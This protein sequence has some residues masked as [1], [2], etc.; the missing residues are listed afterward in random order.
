MSSGLTFGYRKTL[1]H[2]LGVVLGFPLMTACVGLGLGQIFQLFPSSLT[3]LKAVGSAYLLWLAWHIAHSKP[4]AKQNDENAKPLGF[5]AVV[6][7]QW[8][9][10][11]NWIKIMTAIAVYLAPSQ[12]PLN[13]LLLITTVFFLTVSLSAN[14]W[15]LAGSLLQKLIQS[16]TG[17]RR[18]NTA[19]AVVLVA[20]IIPTF[21]E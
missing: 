10:V 14:T 1:P 6:F 15:T 18:F 5:F 9:N 11:K 19:M 12:P 21:F 3:V 16:D 13:Q 20:S 8:A 2:I 17:I 4:R 7:F